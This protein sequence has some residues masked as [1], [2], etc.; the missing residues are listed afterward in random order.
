MSSVKRSNSQHYRL[1]GKHLS[2]AE[3]NG[4]MGTKRNEAMAEYHDKVI[5]LQKEQNSLA[6]KS[7]KKSLFNNV[8]QRYGLKK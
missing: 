3:K 7:Q 8:K 4:F 1:G 5:K 2:I 6:T